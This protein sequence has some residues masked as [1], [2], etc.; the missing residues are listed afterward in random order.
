MN[1]EKPLTPAEVERA[2]NRNEGN[3]EVPPAAAFEN[4]LAWKDGMEIAYGENLGML[5][6]DLGSETP[7]FSNRFLSVS[8]R[9]DDSRYGIGARFGYGSFTKFSLVERLN[10]RELPGSL[11]EVD[12]VYTAKLSQ[13]NMPLVE[14]F[15]GHRFPLTN[16]L[17]LDLELSAGGSTSRE[18]GS[19]T[20]AGGALSL[21]WFATDRLGVQG[22][23]S[24]GRYWY[25][26]KDASAGKNI[27][28]SNVE[29]YTGGMFE[30]RYGLFYHF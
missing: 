29:A 7:T 9:F 4:T 17:A 15:V 24:Y 18:A 1:N 5:T 14:F 27:D 21:I 13:S 26:L 22:G 25:S 16:S 8:Y 10:I 3:G 20:K 6:G 11:R 2:M 23:G 19:H 28:D 30:G 12:T